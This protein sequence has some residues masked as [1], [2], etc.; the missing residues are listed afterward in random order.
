MTATL[1]DSL[2]AT[3][4]DY[5]QSLDPKTRKDSGIYYTPPQIIR[6]I[7]TRTVGQADVTTNPFVKIL[8]PACG[9]GLFLLAAYD[10]LLNKF[11]A[12][13]AI[14]RNRYTDHEYELIT[15]GGSV[16]L[17]GADYWCEENLHQHLI[18]FC[19]F[20]ADSDAAALSITA[21]SLSAKSSKQYVEANLLLCDSLIKWEQD[22]GLVTQPKT[23]NEQFAFWNQQF[24]YVIG[25]PPYIPVTRMHA[26][27][28]AYYRAN[29]QCAEGRMNTFALFVERAIEKA[30]AKIGLI[31]P[32]RLLLNTQY[33]TIRRYILS[34]TTLE[35]IYE[36][37][38]G[39]FDDAIVDTVVL[40]MGKDT[41]RSTDSKLVIERD[42][43]G[44]IREETVDVNNLV[45]MPDYCI[46]FT[47]GS[48]EKR[49]I[50]D[51]ETHSIALANIAEIRDGIIQGAVGNELFL[52]S[53]SR[54][55]ERCKPVLFGY[56]IEAYACR[57]QNQYIW[58]D[59]VNLTKLEDS[60]TQGRER[61]LRLRSPA[62]FEHP[63][64]LSR[65]TADHIIAAMD[66]QG[67]YYMNT[68]HGTTVT[69]PAFDPWYVLAMMNS[70]LIRCWYAWRFAETGR[71]FAQVKIAN[72]KQMPVL[73]LNPEL[74]AQI[75]AL[76]QQAASMHQSGTDCRFLLNKIDDILYSYSGLDRQA[77][78]IMREFNKDNGKQAARRRT[79]RENNVNTIN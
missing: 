5:E 33:S 73:L 67:Y 71:S 63:K 32:S 10:M 30:S 72:L 74:R 61:G 64:I 50:A 24:D 78:Q 60:R 31:V 16:I 48:K 52:G 55:D 2:Q 20:G 40:I 68:L 28:K 37:K 29:Y 42:H 34:Q 27:Q 4:S 54:V 35:R 57:W 21:A 23:Q 69:D 70:A 77:V 36:A 25:N 62:V 49:A 53:H 66:E 1:K 3:A 41:P 6:Y 38:E 15:A 59:P 56:M 65:Q 14:L 76:A 58:Y 51:L 7:L 19:L 43:N 17:A 47:A 12:D 9:S 75:A 11:K 22:N 79:R 13:L 45:T 44:S 8:D 26:R 39:V 46:S 18:R